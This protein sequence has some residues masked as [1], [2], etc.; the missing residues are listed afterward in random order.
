MERV[1]IISE[2]P[3]MA[4]IYRD[5]VSKLG[6]EYEVIGHIKTLKQVIGSRP[7]NGMVLDVLT[8]V[9]GSFRDK[10]DIQHLSDIYPTLRV[11]WDDKTGK[12][13][14]M[15]IGKTI[16]K[17]NPLEDFL[18]NFCRNRSARICRE[19]PRYRLHFNALLG[20]R[21]TCSGDQTEK[22]VTLDISRGG[23]FLIS[24]Q[25]WEGVERAW[26]RFLDIADPSPVRVTVRRR[27]GWG[28]S[29]R[30]PGIGVEFDDIRPEQLE[31]ISRHFKKPSFP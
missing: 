25:D 4:Q 18:D 17:D 7:F 22:T 13:R 2:N 20:R 26:I 29:M 21:E 19:N 3:D 31:E 10:I 27:C 12:I 14:G 28:Q 8:A 30:I 5:A 6:W 24:N 16:D 15:V 23:C 11:R 9:R 1:L